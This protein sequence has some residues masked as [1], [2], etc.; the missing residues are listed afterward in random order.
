MT[1][2]KLKDLLNEMPK[3]GVH[4][5]PS[6][7]SSLENQLKLKMSDW[8]VYK[9][10]EENTIDGDY[11]IIY[12][13]QGRILDRWACMIKRV[14]INNII[15]CVGSTFNLNNHIKEM[16]SYQV[17]LTHKFNSLP[18][19]AAS[20]LYI[21]LAKKWGCA[22]LSGER[23]TDEGMNIWIEMLTRPNLEKE[24]VKI[25]VRDEKNRKEIVDYNID[26]LF[27]IDSKFEN[28]IIGIEPI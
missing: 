12:G 7:K 8:D 24:G 14:D 4:L 26:D 16:P 25:F 15:L 2:I 1:H 23:L 28:I 6:D 9:E 17:M 27:G 5:I 11:N 3:I 13:Y 22:I 18:N 10:I 21:F 19:K 20:K